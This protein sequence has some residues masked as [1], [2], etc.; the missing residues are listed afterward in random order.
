MLL[1]NEKRGKVHDWL[2]KYIKDGELDV[3]TGYFTVGPLAW[4]S[5]KV[6]DEVSRYRMVLGDIVHQNSGQL[7]ELQLLNEEITVES[8]FQLKAVAQK[9]IDL[10]DQ[11]NVELKT[12]EPNFC[13]AKAYI[14]KHSD[15]EYN[16]WR[17]VHERDQ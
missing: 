10:L 1:D 4:L 6:N 15:N 2:A 5:E 7:D 9:A 13:H 14:F 3:V 12:Q 17:L 11:E 8:A 16:L